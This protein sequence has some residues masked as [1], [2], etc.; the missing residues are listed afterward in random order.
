[1]QNALP[2]AY[3]PQPM[4]PE[5]LAYAVYVLE[6]LRP[7]LADPLLGTSYRPPYCRGRVFPELIRQ[8]EGETLERFC[9]KLVSLPYPK[10]KWEGSFRQWLS[11]LLRQ[12][13]QAECDHDAANLYLALR[14][15]GLNQKAAEPWPPEG[16]EYEESAEKAAGRLACLFDNRR[17][18]IQSDL[19]SVYPKACVNLVVQL[20]SSNRAEEYYRLRRLMSADRA[21]LCDLAR[22]ILL[23]PGPR[24][25]GAQRWNAHERLPLCKEV[26]EQE[27]LS[28]W[29]RVLDQ[30][31]DFRPSK[32]ESFNTLSRAVLYH[33]A[34]FYWSAK[35]LRPQGNSL[36]TKASGEAF[37]RFTRE[38]GAAQVRSWE[39][40]ALIIRS[41]HNPKAYLPPIPLEKLP[42][43]PQVE[44]LQKEDKDSISAQLYADI[45]GTAL[46][47]AYAQWESADQDKSI[48]QLAEAFTR[49]TD[50]QKRCQ[51]A[52]RIVELRSQAA[53]GGV[54]A[55]LGWFARAAMNLMQYRQ[56]QTG[57]GGGEVGILKR[58]LSPLYDVVRVVPEGM[59][60]TLTLRV[61]DHFY[62]GLTSAMGQSVSFDEL[63]E[64]LHRDQERLQRLI[65]LVM[66]TSEDDRTRCD[67]LK[68]TMEYALQIDTIRQDAGTTKGEKCSLLL[69]YIHNHF[70]SAF[71]GRIAK[72]MTMV[73]NLQRWVN[74]LYGELS[75]APVLTITVLNQAVTK[76]DRLYGVVANIGSRPAC[77]LSLQAFCCGIPCGQKE[78]AL[79]PAEN[80][81]APF[82]LPFDLTRVEDV[83]AEV[84]Y[85]ISV[86]YNSPDGTPCPMVTET[87]T[88]PLVEQQPCRLPK[89][90][91]YHMES[92]KRREDIIGRHDELRRLDANFG[93]ESDPEGFANVEMYGLKRTGKSSLLHVTEEI[94][95][96]RKDVLKVYVDCE[97]INEQVPYPLWEVF[98]HRPLIE[99][100]KY[101][102]LTPEYQELYGSYIE[103]DELNHPCPVGQADL[104]LNRYPFLLK[105]F[106]ERMHTVTGLHL[107]LLL[108]EA[109]V[110]LNTLEKRN[111]STQQLYK[112]LRALM[113]HTAEF[114]LVLCGSDLLQTFTF[115]RTALS[116]MLDA[117]GEKMQVGRLS[118]DDQC[119]LLCSVAEGTDLVYTEDAKALAW[120]FTAGQAWYTKLMGNRILTQLHL[121]KRAT[122]YPSDVLTAITEGLIPENTI[123]EKLLENLLPD[124]RMVARALQKC[125]PNL[126]ALVPQSILVQSMSGELAP[127]KVERALDTLCRRDIVELRMVGNVPHY[128]F[129][130]GLYHCWFR[131]YAQ[132]QGS[133]LESP[134]LEFKE[135]LADLSDL[136]DL[137]D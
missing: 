70:P 21:A 103:A 49:E 40:S 8:L 76:K 133:T 122:V 47:K 31:A 123:Y 20:L 43:L 58:L 6:W 32:D 90:N 128:H 93:P 14:S 108:D 119:E 136:E 137:E 16:K 63:A 69:T 100:R 129:A 106:Y 75:D 135:N 65:R 102:E 57:A 1:V 13:F 7:K 18:S 87:G 83:A 33:L 125:L 127:A 3:L 22:S 62:R 64:V 131:R 66:P 126:T 59:I 95:Q 81:F 115:E 109:D 72:Q 23:V 113:D 105:D 24:E 28:P 116:Q 98:V 114:T 51:M 94:L 54:A 60:D 88:L 124:E 36:G 71:S 86:S 15:S 112:S 52:C 130:T 110:L 11:E 53:V 134:V 99:A 121:E 34:R 27:G 44:T 89:N 118:Y 17:E 56:E 45:Q 12:L 91:A 30:V 101:V 46:W 107:V 55:T 97:N 85:T 42:P 10:H 84:P 61:D 19:G 68:K 37:R 38:E 50:R 67:I 78:L 5:E 35:P 41:P 9:A 2:Q 26:L 92:I 117:F 132:L 96:Q 120:Q 39:R 73:Q 111:A 77:A 25:G 48:K 29:R 80:N 104:D 4:E 79:L 74:D 82:A